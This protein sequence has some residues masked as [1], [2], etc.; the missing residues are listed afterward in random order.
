MKN[1]MKAGIEPTLP[2]KIGL[3][4]VRLDN[5]RRC[6][7]CLLLEDEEDRERSLPRFIAFL[8]DCLQDKR[9]SAPGVLTPE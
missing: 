1:P 2:R 4:C 8:E 9:S 3:K 5:H 7:Y 6:R